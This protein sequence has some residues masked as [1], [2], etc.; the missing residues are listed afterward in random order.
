MEILI[1]PRRET[2]LDRHG[3]SLNPPIKMSGLLFHFDAHVTHYTAITDCV[4]RVRNCVVKSVFG[5][6][7]TQSDEL[8]GIAH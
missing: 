2:V 5:V 7:V 1:L 4:T 8:T 3:V 6:K